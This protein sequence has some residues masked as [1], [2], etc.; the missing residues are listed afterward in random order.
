MLENQQKISIAL[1][2]DHELFRAG[3]KLILSKRNDMEIVIEAPNGEEFLKQLDV[4]QPDIVLLDIA[5]PVLNGFETAKLALKKYPDIKIIILTM[6]N[7]EAYYLKMIELGVK[8]FILKK[9]GV[10]ELLSA[11]QEVY[12]GNDYFSSELLTK[13][14]LSLNNQKI[15][16]EL[17]L[18]ENEKQVLYYLC[19][20]LVSKEIADKLYLS[21]KSIE[22]Y[23]SK[24][25]QKTNT[26]N[27]AHLVMHAL[28]NRLIEL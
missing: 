20:G 8:G 23:R 5:M 12:Q 2:D 27:S 19:N 10:N 3:I 14:V 21:E 22:R 24:L 17:N 6:Q 15:N 11:I 7:D 1:V 28:K 18:N 26:R 13:L 25:L 4:L 16:N 9:S